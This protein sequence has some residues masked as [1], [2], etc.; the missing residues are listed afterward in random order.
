MFYQNSISA[1]LIKTVKVSL[2]RLLQDHATF[3]QQVIADVP[4]DRIA[5]EVKI[6]VHVFSE[7]RRIVI[8]VCFGIAESFQ[9]GVWLEKNVL[10]PAGQQFSKN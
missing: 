4:S 1:Y 10:N 3:L 2:P 5:F 8:A 7:P 6:D 9:D